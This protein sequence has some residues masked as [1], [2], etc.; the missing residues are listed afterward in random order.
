MAMWIIAVLA[1]R[2]A[3]ASRPERTRLCRRGELPR[4]C[5]RRVAQRPTPET[6]MSVCP[7]GRVCRS[8]PGAR[9][10]VTRGPC[11]R[12]G[13]SALNGASIRTN[14][15]GVLEPVQMP[16]AWRRLGKSASLVSSAGKA[17]G[18]RPL[19][20][21]R[22]PQSRG[23]VIHSWPA[24]T[25]RLWGG[26]RDALPKADSPGD[27]TFGAGL[28]APSEAVARSRN[29]GTR[30]RCPTHATP[31][32]AAAMRSAGAMRSASPTTTKVGGSSP[33]TSAWPV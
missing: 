22:E 14:P 26:F 6:I 32:R 27:P 11:K 31:R 12:A 9:L 25:P 1:R 5:F 19:E 13:L 29:G 17:C 33:V 21:T 15:G 2:R 18:A 20:S 28:D 7:S 30:P 16:M 23:P 8:C 10:E 24:R 4:P 3:S